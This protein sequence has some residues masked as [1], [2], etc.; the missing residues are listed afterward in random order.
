M[1]AR[2]SRIFAIVVGILVGGAV[3]ATALWFFLQD[4]RDRQT[5]ACAVNRAAIF[6][7]LSSQ[8]AQAKIGSYIADLTRSGVLSHHQAVTLAAGLLAGN[9]CL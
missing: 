5:I 7:G 2:R 1:A 8:A 4:L 6:D 9:S 3:V